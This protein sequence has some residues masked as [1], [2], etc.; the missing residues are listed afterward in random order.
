M[1]ED[2]QVILITGHG[3]KFF[4]AG[5]NINMLANVTQP[6]STSSVCMP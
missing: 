4:S 6:L 2:V 5:A 1:D 3:E